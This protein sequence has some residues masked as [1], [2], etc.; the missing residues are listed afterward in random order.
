MLPNKVIPFRKSVIPKM[1]VIL[2]A[3]EKGSCD[4][5]EL[6]NTHK[7]GFSSMN[8]FVSTIEYLF[9]LNKVSMTDEGV[10]SYVA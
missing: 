8:E 2:N 6:Y 5:I 9:A 1:L 3:L 10:L 7:S 4:V